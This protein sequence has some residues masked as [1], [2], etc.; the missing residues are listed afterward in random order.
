[1]AL[2]VRDGGALK[3]CVIVNVL[4][5]YVHHETIIGI[6]F[7][8]EKSQRLQHGRNVKRWL[9]RTFWRHVE[10]VQAN[11]TSAVNIGMVDW[12][13]VVHLWRLERIALWYKELQP[14]L[15]AGIRSSLG[16]LNH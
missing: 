13:H 11:P 14:E 6:G 1:M 15:S 9:P 3:A 8:H 10:D 16:A 5:S 2:G 12:R 4:V 7:G